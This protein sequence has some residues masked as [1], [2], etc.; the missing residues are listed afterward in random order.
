[1]FVST[2]HI[3]YFKFQFMKSALFILLISLSSLGNTQINIGEIGGKLKDKKKKVEQAGQS[4]DSKEEERKK[5][6]HDPNQPPS[7]DD[8]LYQ[9]YKRINRSLEDLSA[10]N[11]R[12]KSNYD[13]LKRRDANG[14]EKN[15]QMAEKEIKNVETY[16]S[17]FDKQYIQLVD[18]LKRFEDRNISEKGKKKFNTDFQERLDAEKANFEEMYTYLDNRAQSMLETKKNR[19]SSTQRMEE[20]EKEIF[21]QSPSIKEVFPII[22]IYSKSDIRYKEYYSNSEIFVTKVAQMD[23]VK[24]AQLMDEW[25]QHAIITEAT[26][27]DNLQY[28]Y[29]SNLSNYKEDFPN[30][31]KEKIIPVIEMLHNESKVKTNADSDLSDRYKSSKAAKNFM[32]GAIAINATI[33]EL[34]NLKTKVN[35]NYFNILS[36]IP[37]SDFHKEN[38]FKLCLFDNGVSPGSESESL[39]KNVWNYDDQLKAIFYFT[40]KA[41]FHLRGIQI[42]E[43]GG[44][45][46]IPSTTFKI[47]FEDENLPTIKQDIPLVNKMGESDNYGLYDFFPSIES[48]TKPKHSD[49]WGMFTKLAKLPLG[50]HKTKLAI[51]S[52]GEYYYTDL[53]LNVTEEAIA[54][55]ETGAKKARYLG[56]NQIRVAK[57]AYS[58]AN[59]TAIVK[60]DFDRSEFGEPLRTV[61]DGKWII[62]KNYQG[63]PTEKSISIQVVYKNKDGECWLYGGFITQTYEGGG[64][65]GSKHLDGAYNNTKMLCENAYK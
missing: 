20:I 52:Q 13:N 63:V 47:E 4:D 46:G 2:S 8:E 1:M 6:I 57:G 45:E 30:Y 55:F 44:K 32:D 16:R 31:V 48:M 49:Y 53:S 38:F 7:Y 15:F 64:R 62:E 19:E 40:G 65:Y 17:N 21:N 18:S 35:E 3:N 24:L 26:K 23:F 41:K 50:I 59:I 11:K 14:E 12:V 28:G 56:L 29:F 58:D 34:N 25:K 10:Y 27:W 43:L 22:E 5:I 54:Y 42:S 33:P 61:V 39:L 51:K 9:P 60:R 36:T 37:G